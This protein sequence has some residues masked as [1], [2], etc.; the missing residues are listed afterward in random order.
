MTWQKIETAPRDGRVILVTDG[1]LFAAAT[2]FDFMEPDEIGYGD[3]WGNSRRPNPEA[4]KVRL[5]WSSN[6]CTAFHSDTHTSDY[7]GPLLIMEPTH[8]MT[9]PEPPEVKE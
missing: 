1:K 7:D 8:W 3:R 4:G 2:P 9:L 6:G 5:L